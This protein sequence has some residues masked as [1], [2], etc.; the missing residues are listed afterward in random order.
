MLSVDSAQGTVRIS[1]EALPQF[2]NP[3]GVLQGGMA[4]AMLDEAA[5]CAIIV[6]SAKNIVAPTLEFKISFFARAPIGTLYAEARCIRIGAKAAFAEADLLDGDGK[7]L[8]R[9]TSTG[10]PQKNS[11]TESS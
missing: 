11:S 2:C 1:F 7:L 5:V 10:V 9:M 6:K 3:G 8:A 4:A